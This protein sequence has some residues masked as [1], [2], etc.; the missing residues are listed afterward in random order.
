MS[1]WVQVIIFGAFNAIAMS[2]DRINYLFHQYFNKKATSEERN[3]LML[4]ISESSSD[5]ELEL[6]MEN[7]YHTYVPNNNP[8]PLGKREEMLQN[9]L[10]RISA[11]E[12][13]GS[14]APK[15]RLNKWLN[16]AAAASVL[17]LISIGSILFFKDR[18]A[19]TDVNN[20]L[21]QKSF[22]PGG[23]KA[24]LTLNNGKTII[25]GGAKNGKLASQGGV[26]INK[27]YDGEIDY[28]ASKNKETRVAEQLAYNTIRTPKGGQ[29]QVILADGTHVWLNSVSSIKFPATFEGKERN[30][31]ITGEVYFEVAK[32]KA[33]PFFVKASDQVVEVLGTHFNI[34]SYSDEPAVKTTLLEGSV[35][36]SRLNSQ[37]SALLKPGQEAVNKISGPIIVQDADM[38]QAIAW[39]NGF[40]QINDASIETIMR[41]AA[42]WYDVKIVYEGKIPERKFSGRIRRDVNASQFLEMLTYFNVH[43]RIDG[44]TIIV[45]N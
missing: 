3:E 38:Q 35:K 22:A 45:K 21:S 5:D 2:E 16:Y 30:V 6:L 31:E 13:V 36:I 44:D 20:Q 19:Q 33:K 17:I 43:F 15:I 7:V 34:N 1:L 4:L 28:N 23:N 29:Y 18:A 42:R 10:G 39:K 40:F 32:N 9:I 24:T 11:V 12:T 25:L 27:A 37:S 41:Q 14:P 26:I 8:F